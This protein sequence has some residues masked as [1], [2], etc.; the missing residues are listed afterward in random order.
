M[1]VE[2]WAQSNI[3]EKVII[4]FAPAAKLKF[5]KGSYNATC[6]KQNPSKN[7]KIEN[8]K[9]VVEFEY[10]NPKNV[11]VVREKKARRA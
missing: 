7:E 11:P 8:P 5:I 1:P 9:R 10:K 2:K 6:N 4:E 3:I